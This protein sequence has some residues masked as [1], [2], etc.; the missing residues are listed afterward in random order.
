MSKS[1]LITGSNGQLATEFKLFFDDN[2]FSYSSPEEKDLDITSAENLEAV[3]SSEK[4]EIIINCAA[5]NHV[6][7]AEDDPD[8]AFKV[9]SEAV[10]NLAVLCKKYGIFLVH[11][12]SDYV[13]DGTKQGFYI[14]SDIA[15]PINKY[16]QSKLKGEAA[17]INHL[18]KYLI[19][20]L[21][22]VFGSGKQNFLSKV[23]DWSKEKQVLEISADEVSVPTY[24][25]D[26]VDVVMMAIEK[27]INGLYHLNNSGYCSRYELAKYFI[28]K[29]GMPNLVLPVPMSNFKTKAPRPRF[30]AMSNGKISRQ[31]NIT[32]PKWEYGVDRFVKKLNYEKK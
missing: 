2:N 19:M 13:F 6:D 12:S 10:G 27:R 11:F 18:E 29:M 28:G 32:I 5:Y 23:F 25:E 24:T 7:K 3:I 17:V 8:T 26:V 22:W 31:L 4:P 21:S 15:N 1:F 20:R 30:S 14:E 16:G 9:N